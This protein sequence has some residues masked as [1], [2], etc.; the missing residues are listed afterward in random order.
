MQLDRPTGDKVA[1]DAR[2]R[3]SCL[4]ALQWLHEFKLHAGNALDDIT[5][6]HLSCICYFIWF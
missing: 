3:N 1:K 2:E 6:L 4:Q 5:I